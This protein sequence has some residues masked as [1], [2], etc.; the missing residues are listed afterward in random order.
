MS[1]PE[2]LAVYA[3][4]A[5]R[6]ASLTS[7][8][9]DRDPSLTAFINALPEGGHVLDLGCGPGD[10]ARLMAATGLKVHAVDAVAEM[11]ALAAQH[12]GVIAQQQ[13][14]DEIEGSEVYDGIWANFS[15]LHAPRDA[16]P[17]ILKS[18]HTALRSG[19]KFHIGMK[20]GTDTKRDKIGREYTYVTQDGLFDLLST[21]GFTITKTTTGCDKGLDGTYAD[22]IAV[23]ADA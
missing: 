4:Q 8:V 18:L 2:T 6:Y 3:A 22:W 10:S 13:T 15:L 19:G 23:A 20:L 17:R 5:D 11:V 9:S 1:D 16:L 12:R 14:F 7:G 21:A